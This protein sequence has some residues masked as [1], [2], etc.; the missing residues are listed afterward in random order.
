M[1][2]VLRF[3]LILIVVAALAITGFVQFYQSDIRPEGYQPG[4]EDRARALLTEMAIAHGV[5]RWDSIAHYQV[6]FEDEFY[7][8]MG[9]S[10]NPFP[11]TPTKIQLA[12][13]PGDMKTATLAI[14]TGSQKGTIWGLDAGKSYLQTGDATSYKDDPMVHFWLPTYQYFIE[15]PWR[16]LEAT[17]V[18]YGGEAT[19][20]G[21]ACEAVIASWG[22]IEPQKDLDQ[23]VIWIDKESKRIAKIAYT[24]REYYGFLTGAAYFKDYREFDGMLLPQ[25][26]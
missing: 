8:A 15:F 9:E 19:I 24:I 7:G 12:Y 3:L 26:F 2:K 5:D 14:Q 20:D 4:Q 13:T 16:I 18:G 21:K 1:K 23:Y 10:G 22:T 11:E 6:D 17:A 25:R